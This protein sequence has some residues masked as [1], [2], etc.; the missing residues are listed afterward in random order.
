[1]TGLLLIGSLVVSAS[2]DATIRQWSLNPADLQKAIEEAKKKPA[3][4]EQ[5]KQESMLTEEEE[6]E[7][8]ELMEDND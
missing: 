8:A 6:R 1:V 2:I 5:P 4:E 7:L 3:E